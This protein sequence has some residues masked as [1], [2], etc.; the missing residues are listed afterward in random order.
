M[1]K[2]T[3]FLTLMTA[4]CLLLSA[5]AEAA[6]GIEAE[7]TGQTL[8]ITPAIKGNSAN[9]NVGDILEV[10]IP[11][12]PTEGFE[13]Q[14]QNL[15]TNILLQEGIAVYTEDTYPISAGGITT[16]RFKAVGSGK[17]NLSLLYVNTPSGETPSMSKQ[18]FGMPVEVN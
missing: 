5:C 10:Q 17:T 15:D 6:P 7:P 14:V 1:T 11:T 13:W 18:S 16:L 9:L 8:V 3:Q 12:I 2:T 4:V